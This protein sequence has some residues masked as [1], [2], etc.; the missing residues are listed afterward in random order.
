MNIRLIIIDKEAKLHTEVAQMYFNKRSMD[1]YTVVA[2]ED[3]NAGLFELDYNKN[4]DVDVALCGLAG[5]ASGQFL[6]EAPWAMYSHEEFIQKARSCNPKA[7]FLSFST[8]NCRDD[9]EKAGADGY[10]IKQSGLKM[11]ENLE[12]QIVELASRR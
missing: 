10:V 11:Y 2:A 1:R 6:G 3:Q 7:I 9:A 4:G 5:N 8:F 12:Q